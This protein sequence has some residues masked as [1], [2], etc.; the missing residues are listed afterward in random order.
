MASGRTLVHALVGALV[1][2]ILSGIPF[3][4]FLGGV[5]AGFLEGPDARDGSAAGA[6]AGLIVF[7]PFAGMAALL[8]GLFGFGLGLGAAPVEGFLV[9]LVLFGAV[10]TAALGYTVV[11]ALLGGYFG[12]SLAREYPER[13]ASTRDALRFDRQEPVRTAP[14]RDAGPVNGNDTD[15]DRFD[16][17]ADRPDD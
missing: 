4:T 2:L 11:L 8:L 13:H 17:T 12:A 6:L 3:S 5:V 1:A 15:S 9:T 16:P 7:L 10:G 14:D